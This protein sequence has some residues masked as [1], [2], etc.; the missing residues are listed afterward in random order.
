MGLHWIIILGIVVSRQYLGMHTL[1]QC[2]WSLALGYYAH[3]L[4]NAY[5]KEFFREKMHNIVYRKVPKY[6]FVWIMVLIHILSICLTFKLW[7]MDMAYEA[8]RSTKHAAW[9]K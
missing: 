1:D 9:I 3:M 8:T 2:L 6:D 7:Y 4:Y 5:F